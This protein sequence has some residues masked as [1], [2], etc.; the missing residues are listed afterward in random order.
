MAVQ[1]NSMD[2]SQYK[3]PVRVCEFCKP[4]ETLLGRSCQWCMALGYLAHCLHC[5]GSGKVTSG[6]VWDGGRSQYTAVCNPCGGKGVFPAREAD[7]N[8]QQTTVM[9]NS[10]GNGHTNGHEPG[11]R[12]L[13]RAINPMPNLNMTR[14]RK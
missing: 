7:F 1:E 5:N 8:R 2:L 13:P 11:M 6:S 9:A 10:N 14:S 3:G 4:E 12:T